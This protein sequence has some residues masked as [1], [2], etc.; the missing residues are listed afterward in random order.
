M[1]ILNAGSPECTAIG[2]PP[3]Q[4]PA[5]SPAKLPILQQNVFTKT[6]LNS[7]YFSEFS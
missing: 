6:R 5:Q 2:G 7:A 4:S 3:A 1:R